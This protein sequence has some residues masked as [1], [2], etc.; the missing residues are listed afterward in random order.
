MKG[1]NYIF[2]IQNP[3]Y[4]YNNNFIHLT[5]I[6]WYEL[7]CDGVQ[8]VI[9][10]IKALSLNKTRRYENLQL[11]WTTLICIFV[12][13]NFYISAFHSELKAFLIS[14]HISTF[15][16]CFSTKF[17]RLNLPFNLNIFSCLPKLVSKGI[18]FGWRLQ[19]IAPFSSPSTSQCVTPLRTTCPFRSL[20]W[21]WSLNYSAHFASSPIKFSMIISK[22]HLDSCGYWDWKLRDWCLVR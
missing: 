14:L 4:I 9:V 10:H 19:S 22:M 2:T 1:S 21:H 7:Q 8:C 16:I 15:I 6:A 18:F 20:R 13:W 5:L 17:L 12:L 3:K 11:S